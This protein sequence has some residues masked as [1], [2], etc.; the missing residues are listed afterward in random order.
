MAM[1]TCSRC[2]CTKPA[3]EF[4]AHPKTAD[5]LLGKC[6]PCHRADVATNRQAKLEQYRAYERQRANEAHRVRARKAYSQTEQ[7]KAAHG[8]AHQRYRARCPE[9]RA[10]HV[11]LGNAV[12]DGRI[13]KPVACW[14]CGGGPV[15]AHH[16]DYTMPLAV[17]WLC[18]ACHRD[19]HRTTRQLM[20]AAA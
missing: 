2:G 12:R 5:G 15:E 14:H 10:A 18:R 6:K 20:E 11:A 16:A 13:V 7:G 9:R 3:T 8:R 4:Y 19:V 1:K 17:S